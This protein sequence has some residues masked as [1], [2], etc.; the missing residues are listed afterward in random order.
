MSGLRVF[1][2][3]SWSSAHADQAGTIYP[4]DTFPTEATTGYPKGLPGDTR[5]PV[6]LTPYEGP[7]T[8]TVPGTVI[9]SKSISGQIHVQ[10][11]NVIIKNCLVVTDEFE[12]V[13][14][15]RID[16][17]GSAVIMDTEVTSE[18]I[19]TP[20]SA[21]GSDNFTLIR[22]NIHGFIDGIRA[23][24]NVIVR[25][26]YIHDL[27]LIGEDPHNDC[28][29][30]TGGSHCRFIH[31]NLENEHSQTSCFI[32]GPS[33]APIDDYIISNNLMNGGGYV[34]YLGDDP[35]AFASTNFAVI[36][37]RWGRKFWPNGGFFGPLSL[38]AMTGPLTWRGN[39]WDDTEEPLTI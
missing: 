38:S 16:G 21:I 39:V 36:N 34:M 24:D 2:N 25:D 11:P 9:D 26:S 20:A 23:N 35:G 27:R 28:I 3:G 33:A 13:N 10:A 7:D 37:N 30:S 15:I 14:A 17:N 31:N 32:F 4:H 6:A 8:I 19:G 5:T 18:G 12:I 1:R 29:Q 22:V